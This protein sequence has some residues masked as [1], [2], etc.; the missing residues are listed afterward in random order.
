MMLLR[1]GATPLTVLAQ[2]EG[3]VVIA[4]PPR[5]VVHRKDKKWEYAALQRVRDQLGV[6]VDPVH[7]LDRPAS[8]CLLFATERGVAGRLHSALRAGEKTYVAMVRGFC[9]HDDAVQIDRPMKDDKG[10]LREASSV[11]RVLGRAH[12]PRSSLLE[13]RPSTGRYHQVRRHVRDLHHP[14]LADGQH[15]DSKVNRW[16]REQFGVRRLA[17]HA[18]SLELELDGERRRIVCPLF[19]DHARLFRQLPW[20]ADAL[21]ARPELGLEPVPM[22]DTAPA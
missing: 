19:K 2:G 6:R 5:L 20:W 11:V 22:L 17:L 10:V 4:K 7:R 3:W 14:I 13:I 21:A 12:E 16:W 15:G 9:K 18:L 1:K 8:G